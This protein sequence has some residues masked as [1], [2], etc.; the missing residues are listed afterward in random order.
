VYH[1]AFSP[2]DQVFATAGPEHV[3]LWSLKLPS[4]SLVWTQAWR[5]VSG[6]AFAPDGETFAFATKDQRVFV[7]DATTRT[8]RQTMAAH[9]EPS[10]VAFNPD[11]SRLAVSHWNGVVAIYDPA[12]GSEIAVLTNHS[13]WVASLAFSR[14]API[15][16]TSCADQRIRLWDTRTWQETASLKGHMSLVDSVAVSP[17]GRWLASGS[18]DRS[19]RIWNLEPNAVSEKS[20]TFTNANAL[21]FAVSPK[22][23]CFAMVKDDATLSV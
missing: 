10:E 19:V 16:A 14:Q 11:G 20:R 4:P 23:E 21:G 15:L 1:L 13:T 17:D 3:A 6:L 7:F 9:G 12:T 5:D 2:R 8:M 18:K 22:A